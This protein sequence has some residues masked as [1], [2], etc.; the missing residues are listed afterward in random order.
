MAKKL[1]ASFRPARLKGMTSED[2]RNRKLTDREGQAIRRIA[3]QQAVGDDSRVHLKVI[4]RLT[5]QQLAAM[6][7]LRDV[8]PRKKA[9]S[10]RLDVLSAGNK[11]TCLSP[12]TQSQDKSPNGSPMIQIIP[13]FRKQDAAFPSYYGRG[14]AAVVGSC[15]AVRF[16]L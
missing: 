14:Q 13:F 15:P 10:A 1:S 11:R 7:R 4:P 8:R 6:V 16:A 3:A 5:D 9:V 12:G 2:I